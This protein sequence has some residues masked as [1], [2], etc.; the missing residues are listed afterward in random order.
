MKF[1]FIPLAALCLTISLS[2]TAQSALKIPMDA[3]EMRK[4]M[5]DYDNACPVCGTVTH[6]RAVQANDTGT[7]TDV[8]P[9]PED[10]GGN[11]VY[12]RPI[13]STGGDSAKSHG[14]TAT[15][16]WRITVLYD[17]GSYAFFDQLQKP[18]VM[19]GDAVQVVAGRVE[20]R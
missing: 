7:E 20:R 10:I 1:R 12:I 6:V 4:Y 16:K 17:N 15:G 3:A 19:K 14:N 18:E 8:A 2:A 13:F 11:T 9:G 5:G